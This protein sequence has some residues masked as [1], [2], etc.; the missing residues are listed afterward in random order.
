MDF[1][2]PLT[3]PSRIDVLPQNKRGGEKDES[4][5]ISVVPGISVVVRKMSHS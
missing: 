3:V 4:F 2:E 5:L 1:T